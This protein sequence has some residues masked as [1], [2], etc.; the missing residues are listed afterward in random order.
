M[1]AQDVIIKKVFFCL[2]D[3]SSEVVPYSP[4][5]LGVEDELYRYVVQMLTKYFYHDTSRKA[6]IHQESE[7]LQILPE[8]PEQLEAF[9]NCVCE[10][11]QDLMHENPEIQSG[12][13]MFVWATLSEQEYVAFFKSH[14][15]A[16]FC[17]LQNEEGEVNWSLNHL[18]LPGPSP[19]ANEYF[20]LNLN[21]NQAQVSDFECHINGMKMNYLAEY[22]LKLQFKPSE[23]VTVKAIDQ[24]VVETIRH[25]YEEQA[26]Q[27]IM[28]Y[29]TIVADQVEEK[30][31]IDVA[32]LEQVV[33]QDNEKAAAVYQTVVEEQEIPRTPVYVSKKTERKLTK[34]QKLI[35][36]SGIEILVPLELLK[37]DS[38]FEYHQNDDGKISILIKEIS[39]IENK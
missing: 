24:S 19:K 27:K 5:V 1:R 10:Q 4:Q 6:Y 38:I 17:A 23:A 34:K 31:Q 7:L 9:V 22:I 39:S 37:D 33:F 26:P 15:Q 35:T 36:D 14:Y 12:A 13:G 3:T 8:D 16:R 29:K 25:C 21:E 28:E 32:E 2:F 20:Y 30:G 11:I 18:I